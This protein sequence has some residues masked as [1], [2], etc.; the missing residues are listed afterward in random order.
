MKRFY[1][2]VELIQ[3]DKG[4]F[5]TLDGKKI[6]TPSRQM[7][8]LPTRSLAEAIA[9]EWRDQIEDIRP[10]EMPLTQL[11]NTAID[12]THP[13][14]TAVIEQVAAYAATDLLCYRVAMPPDLAKQQAAYWQPLLDWSESEFGTDLAV[15]T[16]LAP[17]EQSEQSLLAIYTVVAQLD[18]FSLTGLQ[19][20]T[21]ASGSVVIGLALLRRRLGADEACSLAQLDEQYQ[22]AQWGEDFDATEQRASVCRAIAISASFM[23]YSQ[24]G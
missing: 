16:D 13:H 14:R 6:R 18:I 7:L 21:A 1:K 3:K 17:I 20:A 5:I 10:A 15:T 2:E 24:D 23:A 22:S 12:Q 8:K 9:D 4:H 19:A 11:A